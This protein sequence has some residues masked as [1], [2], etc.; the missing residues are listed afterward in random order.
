MVFDLRD[1]ERIHIFNEELRK[2]R[3]VHLHTTADPRSSQFAA[4]ARDFATLAPRVR[5]V[6]SVTDESVPPAMLIDEGWRYHAVPLSAELDPFLHLLLLLDGNGPLPNQSL[7]GRLAT[8]RTAGFLQV[9]IAPR[10]PFC[11]QVVKQILVLPL[12]SARLKVT[13]IDGTLFP[14]MAQEAKV[15][16][17]PTV[18]LDGEFRWAGHVHLEELVETLVLRDATKLDQSALA[19]MLKEGNASELAH[20]MLRRKLVFPAFLPLLGHADWSVRLGAMVV[21]EEIADQDPILAQQVIEPIWQL[22]ESAP[23]SI[24]GDMVYL[25]GRL[26]DAGSL[27]RLQGMLAVETSEELREVL[28]EAL[29]ALERKDR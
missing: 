27:E 16:S 13:V 15:R 9:F 24:R 6:A 3:T 22:M 28:E 20:M 11:P 17:A 10:C 23:E 12:A 21:L 2:E 4:F 18:I 7:R 14:E 19:S 26:G 1:Q 8:I 5:F 29:A 25:L